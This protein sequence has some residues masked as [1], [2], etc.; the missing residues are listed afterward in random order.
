MIVALAGRRIDEPGGEAIHFPLK[1]INTVRDRLKKCFNSLKPRAL[2]CSGACGADLLALAVAGELN[3][4]RSMVIPFEPQLFKSK[5]VEDRPGN[6]GAL[7]DS[8]YEQVN[9]EEKVRVMNYPDAEDD[10]YRKTNIEILNRAE[11]LA[12]Q[13]DAEKN[14]LVIIVWD[15]S[16]KNKND[17]TSHFKKEAELRGFKIEEINTLIEK[18]S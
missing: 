10:T 13:I 2:V 9:E 18:K 6:W 16:P 11:V 12:E 4:A 1:N 7:F 15:G 8:M 3:I 17:I 5:S 14:I